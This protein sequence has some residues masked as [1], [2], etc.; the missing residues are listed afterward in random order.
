MPEA[1]HGI[2]DPG[3][4]KKPQPAPAEKKRASVTDSDAKPKEKAAPI[5]SLS[6]AKFVPSESGLKFNDK[7][8]VQVSVKYKE[9][10]SRTRVTFR[11]FCNYKD[12]KQDFNKKVDA[13]ESNGI[14]K[15]ELPLYYPDEY[16]SGPVEYF[17][18]AEHCVGDKVIDSSK[19]K[20]ETK[21]C[22][23]PQIIFSK[24]YSKVNA[25]NLS[26]LANLAYETA[27][28]VENYFTVLE[29]H[30]NRTFSSQRIIA[31]PF[32]VD[33]D[34][35]NCFKIQDDKNDII[36]IKESDTQGFF[37]LNNK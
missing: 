26:L 29:A 18:T 3:F 2:N 5:A 35:A 16:S 37:A 11:I 12:K 21:K 27:N 17:F 30:S 19:L 8:V 14:A 20:I 13:N 1:W 32:L 36:D 31:S 9:Q 34:S 10:T 33:A 22:W 23:V 6:D 28:N 25:Y 4:W 15:T 7:C 24:E